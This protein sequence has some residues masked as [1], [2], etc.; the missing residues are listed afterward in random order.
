MTRTCSDCA[1]A[2]TRHSKTG[3]CKPC[4]TR[5]SRQDPAFEERRLAGLRKTF[6]TPEYRAQKRTERQRTE[7][8]RKDDPVWQAYKQA[9]GKRLR[10]DF[11]AHPD[12]K[13]KSLARRGDVG[14]LLTERR[15]G[16]CPV[17]RRDQYQQLRKKVGV[18]EARRM[19]EAEMTPFE[20]QMSRLRGGA[21]L[22]DKPDLRPTGPAYSL[23]GNATA[24]CG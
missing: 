24:L 19:I 4:A 3:R 10:A 5:L 14:K 22:I 15:I 12:A 23:V 20:R 2:I 21:R 8:A 7:I 6:A 9:S 17:E 11:D 16:W 18:R 1:T 13:A